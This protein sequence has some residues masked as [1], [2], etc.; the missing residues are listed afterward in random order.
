MVLECFR[1]STTLN[2]GR[3]T[4]PVIENFN[5][6]QTRQARDEREARHTNTLGSSLQ[7]ESSL[8]LIMS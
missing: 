7:R 2:G 8:E 5:K 6:R 3:A 1:E 4:N